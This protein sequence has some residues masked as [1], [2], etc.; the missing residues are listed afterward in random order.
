[1]NT[2]WEANPYQEI[3]G[4]VRKR[5]GSR[6]ALVGLTFLLTGTTASL[7]FWRLFL[8]SMDAGH[9]EDLL[10]A[11]LNLHFSIF[12]HM[13]HGCCEYKITCE[14]KIILVPPPS[15]EVTFTSTFRLLEHVQFVF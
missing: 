7:K 3:K 12:G 11:I 8:T 2:W 9:G 13:D 4:K 1:M 14:A 10:K 6:Q 15:S 5:S